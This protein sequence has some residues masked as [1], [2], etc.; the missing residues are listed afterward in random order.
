MLTRRLSP[1]D[2]TRYKQLRIAPTT[3]SLLSGANVTAAGDVPLPTAAPPLPPPVAP[4][5]THW[6]PNITLQLLDDHTVYDARALPQHPLLNTL[7]VHANRH[8]YDPLV[9]H[10][11]FFAF[12]DELIPVN[13]S[14][15]VVPLHIYIGSMSM[16]KYTMYFQMSEAFRMHVES[17]TMTNREQDDIKRMFVDTNVYLLGLTMVV[18]ILHTVF[19]VLAFKNDIQHFRER[20]S[21]IGLSA[22]TMM[23]NMVF[24]VIIMLYL[25]D[26]DTSVLVLGSSVVGL[27][28]D[29]WK[30]RKM[31]RVRISPTERWFGVVP[32]LRIE[33]TASYGGRTAEY[34]AMAFRYLSYALWPL[35]AGYAVYT[36]IYDTHKGWYS[37]VINS[38]VGAVYTF[39]AC[40]SE[41]ER[42]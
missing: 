39:G 37:W 23:M 6:Q 42:T 19:D 41:S 8:V 22:R 25:F 28:I 2:L 24:Q 18:S 12:E 36:L 27:L 33:A 4:I 11:T 29:V 1:P 31:V 30:L 13:E 35:V 17:G 20:R 40:V 16:I 5:V 10:N 3:F 26:N 38:L 32:A 21:F 14:I 15:S 34:D 9:F 7:T